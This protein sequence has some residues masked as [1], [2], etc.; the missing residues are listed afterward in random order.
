M[1]SGRGGDGSAAYLVAEPDWRVEHGPV[2]DRKTRGV[3]DRISVDPVGD[4]PLAEA[5]QWGLDRAESVYVSL[6]WTTWFAVRGEPIAGVGPIELDALQHVADAIE[7]QKESEDPVGTHFRWREAVWLRDLRSQRGLTVKELAVRAKVRVDDL[8]AFEETGGDVG[9]PPTSPPFM[10]EDLLW[11][12]R[13]VHVL[14]GLGVPSDADA[15]A[16]L[17]SVR[18]PSMALAFAVQTMVKLHPGVMLPPS[19]AV[20]ST[21]PR[22]ELMKVV[23]SEVMPVLQ[24]HG[25]K[26]RKYTFTKELSPDADAGV[27]FQMDKSHPPS[28]WQRKGWSP[29]N[30]PSGFFVNLDV[31]YRFRDDPPPSWP[32]DEITSRFRGTTRRLEPPTGLGIAQGWFLEDPEMAGRGLASELASTGMEYFA[33][34]TVE[35]VFEAMERPFW[36]DV[37]DDRLTACRL[38]C[39]R[40]DRDRAQRLFDLACR[41]RD[42]DSS[43]HLWRGT[44]PKVRDWMAQTYGLGKSRDRLE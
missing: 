24:A 5:L 40:G 34:R 28:A 36:F 29:R 4:L 44:D 35:R 19:P 9:G 16:A 43:P 21:A 23:M 3:V 30:V 37:L 6:S 42:P 32:P 15:E 38:A 13:V 22:G 26:G 17:R 33:A 14:A 39:L 25:F 31:G 27:E 18:G 10:R 7:D 12:V 20:G 11:L 2:L 41:E 1:T 8:E